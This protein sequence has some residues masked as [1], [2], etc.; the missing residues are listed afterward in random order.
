MIRGSVYADGVDQVFVQCVNMW[1]KDEKVREL[2]FGKLA[3][4][5]APTLAALTGQTDGYMLYHDHALIKAPW[6]SPT[7]WHTDQQFDPYWSEQATM[8][9]LS[10]DAT[11]AAN[12]AL[13][14]LP[15]T[16]REARREATVIDEGFDSPAIGRL[17]TQ[18]P[19]WRDIEPVCVPTQPGDCLVI[20]PM[21]AH[22]AGANMTHRRRRAF[23]AL[24]MPAGAVFNGQ[25]AALP[26]SLASRLQVGDRIEDLLHLPKFDAAGRVPAAPT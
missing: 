7:N 11:S 12:G 1:K 2:L 15:G 25:S 23:A 14:F 26:A 9:W 13:C 4:R 20:D 16:Q 18:R 22:A 5:L 24:F 6:G 19:E 21:V 17:F 8:V 3:P 10:L